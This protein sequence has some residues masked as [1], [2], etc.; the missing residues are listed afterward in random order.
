MLSATIKSEAFGTDAFEVKGGRKIHMTKKE[1]ELLAD[2]AAARYYVGNL[3]V[4]AKALNT[5]LSQLGFRSE[6]A[7]DY[8]MQINDN[9]NRLAEKLKVRIT[10]Q[11]EGN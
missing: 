6:S 1:K 9:L 7:N 11:N 8:G 10:E 2:R 4:Y 5:E 3:L